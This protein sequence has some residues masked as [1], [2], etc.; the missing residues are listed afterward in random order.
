MYINNNGIYAHSYTLIAFHHV[1]ML[2]QFNSCYTYPGLA[3]FSVHH[4]D[5]YRLDT[6]LE[7]QRLQL[8]DAIKN[9]TISISIS[10]SDHGFHILCEL[11][12]SC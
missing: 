10:T 11:Y 7:V 6:E 12:S 1:R 4:I 8:D 2:W 9:G 3:P 5:L